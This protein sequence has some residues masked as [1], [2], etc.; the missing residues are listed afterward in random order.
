MSD[1]LGPRS[2]RHTLN[3]EAERAITEVASRHLLA[4]YFPEQGQPEFRSGFYV[5]S[6]GK[7]FVVS[8][9]HELAAENIKNVDGVPR[10]SQALEKVRYPKDRNWDTDKSPGKPF[11][12]PIRAFRLTPENP[13]DLLL[14]EVDPLPE[15][16]GWLKPYDLSK[17]QLTLPAVESAVMG[18]GWPSEY[19]KT[20]QV[21]KDVV[22]ASLS[23]KTHATFIKKPET[24]LS[25]YDPNYHFVMMHN[26]RQPIH[27]R[28]MS[29]GPIWKIILPDTVV[30]NPEDAI[31]LVGVQSGYYEQSKLLKATQIKYVLEVIRDMA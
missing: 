3:K 19:A 9:S 22:Q 1:S 18:F 23:L 25:N 8:A 30:W 10:A 11:K 15:F 27:P 6:G 12:L 13:L 20:R 5:V 28:G 29:G 26:D 16:F 14:M 17:A 4:L 2:T 21:A 31:E 7:H 24:S